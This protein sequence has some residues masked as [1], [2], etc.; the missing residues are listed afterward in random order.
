MSNRIRKIKK[1]I[2]PD[3]LYTTTIGSITIAVSILTGTPEQK[4]RQVYNNLKA[5]AHSLPNTIRG[6]TD[7]VW[8]ILGK[9]KPAWLKSLL[10]LV[11][12]KNNARSPMVS[13]T[14]NAGHILPLRPE[15]F[16]EV[17]ILSLAAE[18][19]DYIEVEYMYDEEGN[20]YTD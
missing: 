18:G 15:G 19:R 10:V 13:I 8:D 5:S 11:Y 17:N 16:R 2:P 7:Y 9:D 1:A 4:A 12:D 3:P 20:A 6:I 14:D